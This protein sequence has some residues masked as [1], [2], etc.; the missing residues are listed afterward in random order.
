MS[1]I[2]PNL[3]PEAD[4]SLQQLTKRRAPSKVPEL[5]YLLI[6]W[7][8]LLLF[9]E[10]ESSSSSP[11]GAPEDRR[12]NLQ[13]HLPQAP[14]TPATEFS[15]ACETNE[16]LCWIITASAPPTPKRTENT[17]S[18]ITHSQSASQPSQCSLALPRRGRQVTDLTAPTSALRVSSS[19]MAVIQQHPFP[20]QDDDWLPL[21]AIVAVRNGCATLTEARSN[22]YFNELLRL[23]WWCDEIASC[24]R[25][26]NFSLFT[27]RW[28]H[29]GVPSS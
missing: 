3:L 14:S 27:D 16:L 17:A 13:A 5:A 21:V 22:F 19:P 28:H 6:L 15:G 10:R 4:K 24:C 9:F 18:C 2:I 23:C 1:V 12:E 29:R 11:P 20:H 25:G 8:H 26:I 7:E